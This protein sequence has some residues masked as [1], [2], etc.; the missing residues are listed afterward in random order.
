MELQVKRF[1]KKFVVLQEKRLP[2]LKNS[3]GKLIPKENYQE[4]LCNIV[5]DAS[6]F[7]KAKGAISGEAFLEGLQFDLNIHHEIHHL[8]SNKPTFQTY[9]EVD[10][11]FRNMV[12]FSI[13]GEECWDQL[14]ELVE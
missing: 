8:F 10:E 11:R 7:S 9:T 6:K 1:N 12:R 4:Q 14:L 2:T 3:N 5:A 13:T